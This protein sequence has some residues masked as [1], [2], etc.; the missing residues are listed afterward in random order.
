[1]EKERKDS[2]REGRM[3]EQE[4]SVR[5]D[6]L[7]THDQMKWTLKTGWWIRNNPP[8]LRQLV[9]GEHI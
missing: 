1:M 4:V 6:G 2:E 9:S 7:G 8:R 3:R 5:H